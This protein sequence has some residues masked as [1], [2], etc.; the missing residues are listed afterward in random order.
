M[1]TF[2]P[3]VSVDLAIGNK[4]ELKS[5]APRVQNHLDL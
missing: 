1:H 4:T 2:N 5:Q 3:A